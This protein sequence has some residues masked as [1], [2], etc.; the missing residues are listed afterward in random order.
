[1]AKL[2]PAA[3]ADMEESAQRESCDSSERKNPSNNDIITVHVEK[4]TPKPKY[5]DSASR[6][7]DSL[8]LTSKTRQVKQTVKLIWSQLR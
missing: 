4:A 2:I 6:Q 7:S 3:A 1:L 8:I 5:L